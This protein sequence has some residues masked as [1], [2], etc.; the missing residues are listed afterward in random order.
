MKIECLD[1]ISINVRNANES[2]HFYGEVLGLPC[3][4]SVRMKDHDLYYF[5]LGAGIRLELIE[6]DKEFEQAVFASESQGMYRHIALQV[7]EILL[8]EAHLRSIGIKVT[9]P[10][11][12]IE[13]LQSTNMLILDPNGVEIEMIEKSGRIPMG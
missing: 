3:V 10:P 8:W 7:S 6:Y 4:S 12:W 9:S 11:E 1:H 2:I 13:D 5:P